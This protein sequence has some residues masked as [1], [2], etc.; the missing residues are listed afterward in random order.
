[1]NLDEFNKY[2]KYGFDEITTDEDFFI[3]KNHVLA[4]LN[5]MLVQHA[6]IVTLN[7]TGTKKYG[8]LS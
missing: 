2:V 3:A 7:A 8:M 5:I 6:S 4:E 1:M